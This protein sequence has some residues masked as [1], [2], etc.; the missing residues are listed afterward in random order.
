MDCNVFTRV[1]LLLD[2]YSVLVVTFSKTVVDGYLATFCA[3]YAW[4]SVTG[5]LWVDNFH[6]LAESGIY[7]VSVG[8]GIETTTCYITICDV[9]Q[10]KIVME[11]GTWHYA[12]TIITEI[13]LVNAN[14]FSTNYGY[15]VFGEILYGNIF[16]C[17]VLYAVFL[18]WFENDAF[19]A[20]SVN[21][22]E[23]TTVVIR[24]RILD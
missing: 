19:T 4:E 21:I 11:T 12:G 6:I 14:I 9:W 22:W 5:H 18:F 16:K 13:A 17:N 1:H 20:G 24:I 3:S 7:A 15:A 10:M 23:N 2:E 8:G